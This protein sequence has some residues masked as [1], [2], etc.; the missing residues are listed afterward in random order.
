MPLKVSKTNCT[1]FFC[2]DSVRSPRK[3]DAAVHD[4]GSDDGHGVA[5]VLDAVLAHAGV[6]DG[7]VGALIHH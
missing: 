6:T 7:H 2:D 4:G 3:E 1:F 5:L